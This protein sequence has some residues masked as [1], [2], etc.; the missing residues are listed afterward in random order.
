MQIQRVLSG[1]LLKGISDPR[2]EMAFITDV[3]MAR[4]LKS[5]RIY[6]GVSGGEDARKEAI[7]GFQKARPFIKRVLARKLDLRYMPELKFYYDE[8]IDYGTRIESVL[9]TIHADYG[10]DNTST[11]K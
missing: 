3:N 9:R 6:F 4:D 5:A 10:S 11:E 7:V 2:L 8:S 1:L